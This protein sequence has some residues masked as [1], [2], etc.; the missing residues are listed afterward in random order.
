VTQNATD[1]L[2][3]PYRCH[4]GDERC[5][6]SS[7]ERS[8]VHDPATGDVLT[9]VPAGTREDLDDAVTAAANAFE[10]WG[11]VEPSERS[12]LLQQIAERI[13]EDVDRLAH[14]ETLEHGRPLADAK[15]QV[16]RCAR[17]FE[18]YGG[19]A[20]KVQGE[21]IPIG[22]EYVDYTIREPVGVTGHIVPWNVPIYLFARSVAPAL[23][24]GNTAV[25][26]PAQLT[27][28]GTI[29]VTRIV[30]DVLPPGVLNVV[31]GAGSV[32]GDAL[33]AHSDV[34]SIV[35]TGS[36]ETGI[37]VGKN[38]A[39]AISDV[40]LE[41]G[42]KSPITVCRDADIGDAVTE[43][44]RGV[45]TGAGQICSASSRALVHEVVHDE[46]IDELVDRIEAFDIGP[47][48]ENPDMGPL[49]SESH[50]ESVLRYIELGRETVGD[51]VVGGDV[52]D[53]DGYFLEPT[54]FD[55]VDNEARIAQEEI[56]GPVLT[57]T[58]FE[59]M[60]EAIRLAND[61]RY[62]LVAGIMTNDLGKAHRYARDV[63]A[64]QIYVN[65]W[66]AGGNETP[67]GGFKES[68]IG[69]D[70]GVQA[71]HNFTQIKNVCLKIDEE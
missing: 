47:G 42:G 23:A 9:Q 54:V 33:S 71:I 51:P 39:S 7:G 48:V 50:R 69:R 28:L 2:S 29:E 12:R 18:Y 45:F 11:T 41:L 56:F 68:G 26:N 43:T 4:I 35:F 67:F 24:A 60:D 46:Y 53:R 63:D 14:I 37:E 40:V 30:N 10:E 1:P 6:A 36:G 59:D 65:E 5:N 32:V 61:V 19:I 25:V 34:E 70:N 15:G 27:P 55:D 16:R 3:P 44:I 62:G 49:V 58:M 66:F 8:A 21:Q 57:V 22:E 13:Q 64:G 31:P 17:H 20:D 52:V 38:A